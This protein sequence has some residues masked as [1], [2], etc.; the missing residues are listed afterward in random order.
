M[1]VTTTKT[2]PTHNNLLT[3]LLLPFIIAL[4][5]LLTPLTYQN[6]KNQTSYTLTGSEAGALTGSDI[7][8]AGADLHAGGSIDLH[9]GRD[10]GIYTVASEERFD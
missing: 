5:I 6:I 1:S 2:N 3:N 10:I 8:N 4:A 9:A 7:I